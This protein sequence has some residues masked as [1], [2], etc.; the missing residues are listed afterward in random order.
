METMRMKMRVVKV[1]LLIKF[2]VQQILENNNNKKNQNK[3]F[4]DRQI[5]TKNNSKVDQIVNKKLFVFSNKNN[6]LINKI[7]RIINRNLNRKLKM[8]NMKNFMNR[9]IK[10]W[11]CSNQTSNYLK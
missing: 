9:K 5:T 3:I 1:L 8:N 11:R 10:P 4:T 7:N 2:M 6:K